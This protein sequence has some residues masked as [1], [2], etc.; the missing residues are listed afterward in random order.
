MTNNKQL[1]TE[2]FIAYDLV[3]VKGSKYKGM[4]K[5]AANA[6]SVIPWVGNFIAA[7]NTIHS[8]YEQ[9]KINELYQE[10]FHTHKVK[11]ESLYRDLNSLSEHIEVIQLDL[12]NRLES[13]EYL[14]LVRKSF[15]SWDQAD[16]KEKRRYI[17][18]LISN[19]ATSSVC[20]DDQVRLF[21]EWIDKY[22]EIHFMVIKAIVNTNGITRKH[23]W[24]NISDSKPRE[25]SSDADLFKLVIRDL[26][27]GGVIRQTRITNY[28]GQ[29]I[30]KTTRSS[31]GSDTLESAFEDSKP[32]ELT[33]LGQ[34]F[35][36]YTMNEVIA[37]LD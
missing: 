12:A 2:E 21:N 9:G 20:H 16:T 19:A 14:S 3:L 34:K 33:E 24:L 6:M 30:K 23:I 27:T 36:H 31:K 11:I 10:W 4:L 5:V 35:V 8:E 28:Q 32:Y 17:V 25:D 7:G 1:R 26:S 37:R 13:E 15:R 18:N 29:F 22:H